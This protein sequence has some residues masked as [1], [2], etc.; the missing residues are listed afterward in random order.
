MPS[1]CRYVAT[2]QRLMFNACAAAS[3][4][5]IETFPLPLS[6]SA[7]KRSDRPESV[8]SCFLADVESGKEAL[9]QAGIGGELL[10]RHAAPG[11]P[12]AHP[13]TELAQCGFCFR[14]GG[15]LHGRSGIRV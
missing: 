6:T 7:R 11:P 4:E 8:A 12:R 1:N 15:D 3:S 9:G 2:V 14:L 5:L 13:A 10:A